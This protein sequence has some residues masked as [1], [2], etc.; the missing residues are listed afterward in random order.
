MCSY[1]LYRLCGKTVT[2]FR[3]NTGSD[4]NC[5]PW[6]ISGWT[7]LLLELNK[8]FTFLQDTNLKL[9]LNKLDV[10]S[11][12]RNPMMDLRSYITE[13]SAEYNSGNQPLWVT[14]KL[15]LLL[16]KD[17][18][19]FRV[20]GIKI[21]RSGGFSMRAEIICMKR[22]ENMKEPERWGSI[23]LK[24]RMWIERKE[25][26]WKGRMKKGRPGPFA[27]LQYEERFCS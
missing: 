5:D 10:P 3:L 21:T 6:V 12:K 24:R 15:L 14:Q 2:L 27:S 19:T 23:K 7:L 25:Q 4:P 16:L 17:S 18:F 13:L 26:E 22:C 1:R 8:N 20:A 9:A 11:P